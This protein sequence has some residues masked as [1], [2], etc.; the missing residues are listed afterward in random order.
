MFGSSNRTIIQTQTSKTTQKLVTVHKTKLLLWPFQSS[1]LNPVEN[2]WGELKRRSTVME[3]WIWRIWR[4]SGWRNGLWSLVR[5]SPT[6][7][8]ITGEYL[9]LLNWQMEVSKS[10]EWK[11]TVNCGQCV[12]E[13]NIYFIMI[14]PPILNSYWTKWK[15]RFLWFFLNKRSKGLIMQINFHSLL[16][17]YLLR[18][19]IILTMTVHKSA[20]H[21]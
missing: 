11:G 17:S 2:E 1:D 7:S 10:I 5:C 8:G 19:P 15:V 14:F 3:L 6:S 9:E 13:K 4:D 16:W 12:L 18:V 21:G 20:W